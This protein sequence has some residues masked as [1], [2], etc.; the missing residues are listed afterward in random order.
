MLAIIPIYTYL[1]AGKIKINCIIVTCIRVQR[2]YNKHTIIPFLSLILK[3]LCI[4]AHQIMKYLLYIVLFTSLLLGSCGEYEKLLKSSDTELKKS[5]AKEFFDDGQF[6]KSS[7]LLSQIIPRYRASAEAEELSWMYAM[8]FLG[9]KDYLMAGS[10]FEQFI[11]QFPFGVHAE[12]ALFYSPYCD[13][14]LSPRPALDQEYTA[15]A[16]E[17]FR[18]FVNRYPNS[19]RADEARSI[20]TELQ[21]KL[22]EK[23]YLSAK[24]YYDM[25]SYKAAIT[26]LENSLK[27]YSN[28]KYREE[29]MFLKL[30]SLFNY[31]ELSLPSRQ[32]ER[33][34]DT[35]DDYYSFMEEFPET[36]FS[37]E[38]SNI[39]EKT[40]GFL[41]SKNI[42]TEASNSG[43]NSGN[44]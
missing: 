9:M 11:E 29:M 26:A 30:N 40:T 31:A 20:I 4:F 3:F 37:K 24:L 32:R 7:E 6:V 43:V 2:L 14:K 23:S 22:V 12:E 21:E 42:S 33:Y 36:E 17:G 25:K 18:L 35:L 8:S 5:K 13:Y 1:S 15:S 27:E 34:Q 44:N 41:K 16:I 38:V 39:F 19:E 28:S 10:Y